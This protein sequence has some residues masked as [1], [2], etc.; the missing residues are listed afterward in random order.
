MD[1]V[2]SHS[3]ILHQKDL[4]SFVRNTI[5]CI[6]AGRISVISNNIHCIHIHFLAF[7]FARICMCRT[8]IVY[9]IHSKIRLMPSHIRSHSYQHPRHSKKKEI[10]KNNTRKNIKLLF[11]TTPSTVN[12]Y[13]YRLDGLRV[14]VC[15]SVKSNGRYTHIPNTQKRRQRRRQPTR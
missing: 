10:N 15:V 7:V 11:I 14:C 13:K 8:H 5:L 3:I 12:A 1:V 2:E 9:T 6:V 4:Y